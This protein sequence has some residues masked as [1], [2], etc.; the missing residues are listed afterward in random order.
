MIEVGQRVRVHLVIKEGHDWKKIEKVGTVARDFLLCI[1]NQSLFQ[2]ECE[3]ETRENVWAK[4][5]EML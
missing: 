2:V 1:G 5:I 3:D 4:Q